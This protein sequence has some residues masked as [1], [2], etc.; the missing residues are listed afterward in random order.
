MARLADKNGQWTAF[1][2]HTAGREPDP[3]LPPMVSVQNPSKLGVTAL[4][5]ILSEAEEAGAQPDMRSASVHEG[6]TWYPEGIDADT[7]A[8][9]PDPREET[10]DT[11]AAPLDAP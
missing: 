8:Y 3:L 11:K 2:A 7:E 6:G 5:R 10:S 1:P 4:C 9:I